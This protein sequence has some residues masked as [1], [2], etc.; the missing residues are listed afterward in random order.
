MIVKCQDYNG[1][2]F[3]TIK[4]VHFGFNTKADFIMCKQFFSF[5]F[6]L[7]VSTGM[8]AQALNKQDNDGKRHGAWKG[9]YEPSKKPRYEGTFNH[10]I[11]TGT[12]KFFAEDATSTL[13]A[14]RKFE[15]DGSC[16]TTF[17][18][19]A[20]NKVSEG[21]E[22]NRM[23]EG[24]WK[25]YHNNAKTVMSVE[26]YKDGKLDGLRK[27]FFPK[28]SVAEESHYVNG[29]KE[30]PYRKYTEKGIV[31]EESTYK[32]DNYHGLAT[33]RDENNNIV[34]QGNYTDGL[35]TGKWKFYTDG[36]LT[37]EQNM[38]AKRKSSS[39]KKIN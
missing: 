18:D 30:G 34:S 28:G 8:M 6:L 27:V 14:T 31:L 9:I 24:E 13:M 25:Y 3:D 2:F 20:G 23:Q 12:F 19:P 4:K 38:S 35:K 7:A 11:E 37:K 16:Y 29:I 15:K 36:K 32:N 5:L 33:Y 10:G 26:K 22:V 21:R 17:F 39:K 1:L